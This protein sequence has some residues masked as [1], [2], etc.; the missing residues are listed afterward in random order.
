MRRV[1]WSDQAR[2][3]LIAIGDYL[4]EFSPA[5][6]RGTASALI[7]LSESLSEFPDRGRPVKFGVRELTSL[8]PYVIRYAVLGAEIQIVTIRLQPESHWP[9]GIS[10]AKYGS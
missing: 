6:V 4:E 9:N 2:E 7:G 3:D 10:E 5:A 1:V 8:R